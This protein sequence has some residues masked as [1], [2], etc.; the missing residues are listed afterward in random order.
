[1]LHRY[2]HPEIP[3]LAALP[4]RTARTHIHTYSLH[5]P[6]MT[7]LAWRY[8]SHFRYIPLLF[9]SQGREGPESVSD[10]ILL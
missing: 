5:T 9:G 1:M 7:R 6:K 8:G 10:I 3:T 4:R 2:D